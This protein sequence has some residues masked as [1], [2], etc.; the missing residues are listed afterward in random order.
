MLSSLRSL[1]NSAA[2][3]RAKVRI[4]SSDPDPESPDSAVRLDLGLDS[5]SHTSPVLTS[6]ASESGLSSL[7][8]VANSSFNGIKTRYRTQTSMQ[9]HCSYSPS[10]LHFLE[11]K[12]KQQACLLKY[13]LVSVFARVSVYETSK[14][15]IFKNSILSFGGFSLKFQHKSNVWSF[16]QNR[17][18]FLQCLLP[19]PQD[20]PI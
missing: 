12:Q 13:D 6:S 3:K 4:N 20:A 5:P 2:K 1:R 15:L 7:S 17:Q 14:A 11:K 19:H 8:S 9:V 10:L 18:G 16:W